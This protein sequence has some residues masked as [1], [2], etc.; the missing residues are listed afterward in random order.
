M[1]PIGSLKFKWDEIQWLVILV[2]DPNFLEKEEESIAKLLEAGEEFN[3]K[4]A[5]A[6]VVVMH[7][8]LY[9]ETKKMDISRKYL[10][11]YGKSRD[12][13]LFSQNST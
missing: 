9:R 1:G 4:I 13:L 5:N 3:Y 2:P 12:I 8:S 6:R 7:P 11:R 10:N